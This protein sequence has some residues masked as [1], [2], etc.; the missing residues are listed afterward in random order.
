M[1]AR[2]RQVEAPTPVWRLPA[3]LLLV[4]GLATL[5]HAGLGQGRGLWT[6]P[7]TLSP[8][9]AS[10]TAAVPTAPDID[11][12]VQRL[13]NRLAARPDDVEGWRRLARAY[14]TLERHD[15][16]IDAYR[17]LLAQA[18]GDADA[19]CELALVLALQQGDQHLTGESAALVQRAL[20]ASPNHLQALAL[21]GGIALE[22]GR[23]QEARRLW[24][25]VLDQVPPGTAL[26]RNIETSIERTRR[27][28][29]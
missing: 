29:P 12:M 15:A 25:R 3:A 7:E 14:E 23:P 24:Q 6:S 13:A 9:P 4:A 21:A 11:A 1:S 10:V 18:P 17:R 5:S 22:A 20:Q 2:L 26:A 28:R 16:A 27:P 19:L 8:A